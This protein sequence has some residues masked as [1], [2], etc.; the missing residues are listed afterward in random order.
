MRKLGAFLCAACA[1]AILMPGA[2]AQARPQY[3]KA[4]K[5]TYGKKVGDDK[6]TCGVCQ[7]AGAKKKKVVSDY[8]K[9]LAEA[10]GA[11]NEKD[12]KKIVDALNTVAKKEYEAGKTYGSLLEKGELPPPAK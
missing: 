6:V 11:K 5:E 2:P 8:G 7:G 9:A 10:L 1:V 3:N 12:E 4:F